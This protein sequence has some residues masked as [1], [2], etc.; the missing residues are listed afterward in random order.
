MII[1]TLLLIGLLGL[2]AG[3][4]KKIYCIDNKVEHI[5]NHCNQCLSCKK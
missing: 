3:L 1:D 4:L 2:Y 5:K